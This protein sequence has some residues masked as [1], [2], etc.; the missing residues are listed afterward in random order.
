MDERMLAMIEAMRSSQ[1]DK[2]VRT[3]REAV[4]ARPGISGRDV[5][6]LLEG[7]ANEANERATQAMADSEPDRDVCAKCGQPVQT[8]SGDR[9]RWVHSSDGS[10]GCRAA[11]FVPDNGWNDDIPRSWMAAPRGRRS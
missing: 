5:L 7:L 10:R 3:V 9:G 2:M 11:T 4:E 1:A 6:A 8:D